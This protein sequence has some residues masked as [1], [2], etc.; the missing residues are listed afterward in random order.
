MNA[1]KNEKAELNT[2]LV[3]ANKTVESQKAQIAA[4]NAEIEPLRKMKDDADAT[5][6]QAEVN[7]YFESIEKND[8]FSEAEL[9]SMRT[10]YVEKCDLDG[11]KAKETELCVAKFKEMQKASAKE[12]ELNSANTGAVLFFST[13]PEN[14]EINNINDFD[15]GSDLFK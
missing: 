13:K 1:C 14:V 5:A 2:L 6:A 8:G 3:E 15:D 9:N 4:L 11:L 7:S 12:A 10:E